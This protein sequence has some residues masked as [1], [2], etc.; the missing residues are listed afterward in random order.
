MKAQELHDRLKAELWRQTQLGEAPKRY[1]EEACV[2]LLQESKGQADYATK[3]RH[4]K[5][6]RNQ[7]A[8]RTL[9]SLTTEMI[10]DGLPTHQARA[11]RSANPLSTATQN[12]YLSSIRRMLSLAVEAGWIKSAPILR[13]RRESNAR[14]KWLTYDQAQIFLDSLRLDWMRHICTFALA[15]GCRQGEIL[16]L[17]WSSVDTAQKVAWIHSD[18]SKSGVA[19]SVPLSADALD[20][21]THRKG[22]HQQHVFTRTKGGPRARHLDYRDLR[23]AFDKAGAPG[24]RFHDLRHTWAS[25]HAQAGTPL[26]VLK[27]LGG[28]QTLEMVKRYAH[29]STEHLSQYANQVTIRSQSAQKQKRPSVMTA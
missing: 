9:C 11:G 13:A 1:F 15:T 8:G 16:S 23:Q 2:L 10:L 25:W 18:L 17:D 19:R 28:W 3:V 12:R 22:W 6:W 21:L 5:Y 27:E 29:L 7:F 20:V 26:F 14:I 4:V 24:F